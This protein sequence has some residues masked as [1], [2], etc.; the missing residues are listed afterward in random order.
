MVLISDVAHVQDPEGKWRLEGRYALHYSMAQPA[1]RFL[2]KQPD[3]ARVAGFVQE[4][5]YAL[6]LL[7][8]N[9]L[10]RALAEDATYGDPYIST[11]NVLDFGEWSDNNP[12]SAAANFFEEFMVGGARVTPGEKLH[13]YVSHLRRRL[14]AG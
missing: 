2:L 1:L 12:S 6:S 14:L 9:E 5:A 4:L 3:E 13:L 11:N 10:D 7:S 8:A